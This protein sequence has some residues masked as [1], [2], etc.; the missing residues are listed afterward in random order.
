MPKKILVASGTSKNKMNA[1]ADLIR[2]MCQERGVE[3]DAK[4]ENL[5]QVNLAAEAPDV[6]V[7][8]GPEKLET[9]VPVINGVAFLTRVGMEKVIDQILAAIRG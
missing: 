3:V 6:I 9:T 2:K 1:V 8:I 5:W 7:V 4:A